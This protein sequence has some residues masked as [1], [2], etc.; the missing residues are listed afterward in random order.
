MYLHLGQGHVVY[1]R[2]VIGIF[3]LEGDT[4][5]NSEF[6]EGAKWGKDVTELE[7]TAKSMV[8]TAKKVFICPLTPGTLEKRWKGKHLNL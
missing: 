6:I 4:P 3:P 8:L 7:G 1:K 5:A 2:D